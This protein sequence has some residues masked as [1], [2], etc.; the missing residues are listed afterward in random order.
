VVHAATASELGFSNIVR[1]LEGICLARLERFDA[2]VDALNMAQG[3]VIEGNALTSLA[4][5]LA[6]ADS[7]AAAAKTAMIDESEWRIDPWAIW[8]TAAAGDPD[9]AFAYLQQWFDETGYFPLQLLWTPEAELLRSDIRFLELMQEYGVSQLWR[10]ELPDLC[11]ADSKGPI[12][13]S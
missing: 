5:A 12:T 9:K 1:T 10:K 11:K 13:C 2:A 3:P 7:L 6:G 4:A 8:L